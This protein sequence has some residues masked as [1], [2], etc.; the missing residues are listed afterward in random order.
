MRMR[1]R[2]RGEAPPP[3][4]AGLCTGATHR[5]RERVDLPCLPACLK[6]GQPVHAPGVATRLELTAQA[7]KAA[8]PHLHLHLEQLAMLHEVRQALQV[9]VQAVQMRQRTAEPVLQRL[10]PQQRLELSP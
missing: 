10:R 4:P 1:M 7:L 5:Q 8:Y 9:Q 2:M 3:E 6:A